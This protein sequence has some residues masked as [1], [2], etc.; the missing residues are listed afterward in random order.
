MTDTVNNNRSV[1][2]EQ[3]LY[4]VR[5]F[6]R[7]FDLTSV[8][9]DKHNFEP[10]DNS[11]ISNEMANFTHPHPVT[12]A[13]FGGRLS[14]IIGDE[15]V[16]AFFKCLEPT[17][18]TF[19]MMTNV[20]GA[21][22]SF[23]HAVYFFD[24]AIDAR[25]RVARYYSFRYDGLD[26]QRKISIADKNTIDEQALI[27]RI[28]EIES[29]AHL[30]GYNPVL[31][32]DGKRIGIAKKWPGKTDLVKFALNQETAYRLLSSAAH[33]HHWALIQIGLDFSNSDKKNGYRL[34]EKCVKGWTISLATVVLSIAYSRALYS[35]WKVSGWNM[36]E[37][38]PLINGIYNK[39]L[40]KEE[41]RFWE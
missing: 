33:G 37:I 24:P 30:L 26:Q 9:I 41:H 3:A 39:L 13:Y 21:L 15:N 12:N 11:I 17:P 4:M 18:T 25:E 6:K 35:L 7:F 38:I 27:S 10:E 20:R 8:L 1:T 29:E 16:S 19:A 34:G 22:E 23:S 31:D 5:D 32:K 2:V 36:D 40:I 28:A 14:M